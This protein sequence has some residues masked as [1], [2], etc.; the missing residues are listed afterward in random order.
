LML[1]WKVP[2]LW[3][4]MLISALVAISVIASRL[5]LPQREQNKIR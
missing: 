1:G 4:G 2:W 3:I 5:N